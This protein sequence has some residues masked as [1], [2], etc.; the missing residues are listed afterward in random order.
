[1]KQL[2][3]VIQWLVYIA[4]FGAFIYAVYTYQSELTETVQIIRRGIWYFVLLTVVMLAVNIWNQALWFSAIWDMLQI[5]HEEINLALLYL[6]SRFISV[7]VPS[8]GLS[9]WVPFLN[10]ARKNDLGVG[11][12]FV[13]SLIYTILWYSSF[14]V[15]LIIGLTHLFIV[16]DLQWFEVSAASLLLLADIALIT[17][18]ALAWFNHEALD[19]V[20]VW[21]SHKLGV[22]SALF[23]A[24]NPFPENKAHD[25]HDDLD[26]AVRSMK[27][28]GKRGL[29]DPA[30]F[31]IINELLNAAMLYTLALAFGVQLT[32]G[33]L[34]AAYSASI[35]FFIISPTPGGLGVVEGTII[36]ILTGLNVPLNQATAI[37]FAYRGIT[38]WV[39]FILGFA[40]SRF[41]N[42]KVEQIKN[43]G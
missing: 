11:S 42:V 19:R 5:Q 18:L 36:L 41:S 28:S 37:T 31:A 35:L 21:I 12:V 10:F 20:L 34:V 33:G 30:R 3:R 7:A 17:G 27:A 2:G 23:N 25:L 39:P 9:G 16:E 1:M 43:E 29:L 15:M 32:F 40:A 22:I 4:L 6:S 8:G 14:A 24:K 26:K 38:F 13:A